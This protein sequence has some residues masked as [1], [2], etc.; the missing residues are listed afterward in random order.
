MIIKKDKACAI[1]LE[2][3]LDLFSLNTVIDNARSHWAVSAKAKKR[4]MTL[5]WDK[6]KDQVNQE[7]RGRYAVETI[8]LVGS[9]AR[10]LDN[11]LL[12]SAFDVLVKNKAL[13]NDN[14]NNIININHNFV[15][16]A[17]EN[18]GVL[19]EFYEA[20]QDKQ[21]IVEFRQYLD[22]LRGVK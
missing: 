20:E 22:R 16:V 1:Y 4:S 14:L 2:L 11:L 3:S 5:V 6:A 19:I 8:W 17:S 12:K 15:T 18:Q 10:D 7:L 13:K 21:K 9:K